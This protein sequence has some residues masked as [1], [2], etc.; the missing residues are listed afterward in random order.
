MEY[1]LAMLSNLIGQFPVYLIYILGIIYAVINY[2][3]YPRVSVFVI[4]GMIILMI[5]SI[6]FSF[7]NI[8]APIYFYGKYSM[9][10][11]QWISIS[12]GIIRSFIFSI[13]FFLI[14]YAVFMDREKK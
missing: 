13:G 11:Y 5:N 1:L 9:T 10:M 3:K 6:F 7:I 8:W 4:I 14:I 12:I 2:N